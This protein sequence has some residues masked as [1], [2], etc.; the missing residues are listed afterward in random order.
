MLKSGNNVTVLELNINMIL[1]YLILYF[2]K[3]KYFLKIS[4]ATFAHA[5]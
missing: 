5:K 3:N 4:Q 2:I 1:K